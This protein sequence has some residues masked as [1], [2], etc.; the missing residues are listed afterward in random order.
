MRAL[1]IAEKKASQF[2]NEAARRLAASGARGINS[3][4]GTT[5]SFQTP[6]LMT[7]P[8]GVQYQLRGVHPFVH[9]NVIPIELYDKI[10]RE[11]KDNLENIGGEASPEALLPLLNELKTVR[12][13]LVHSC[14]A[15]KL[16]AKKAAS[17][18]ALR[19]IIDGRG[20]TVGRGRNSGEYSKSEPVDPEVEIRQ[21][22]L[23]FIFGS[24]LVCSD[25]DNA[26]IEGENI[27]IGDD[28]PDFQQK[29]IMVLRDQWILR[30]IK[31]SCTQIPVNKNVCVMIHGGN[32][33]LRFSTLRDGV[34]VGR[35]SLSHAQQIFKGS[36]MIEN[37]ALLLHA[38]LF[39]HLTSSEQKVVL[40]EDLADLLN[41][42]TD[43]AEIRI[44]GD[45]RL[46]LRDRPVFTHTDLVNMQ[47]FAA[48]CNHYSGIVYD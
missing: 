7:H 14:G 13:V 3:N 21:T 32:E 36:E 6:P 43:G 23:N 42:V 19:T 17:E 30:G 47:T 33:R 20:Y 22:C 10:F 40:K 37:M 2:L 8:S 41:A 9:E 38:I 18:G 15:G 1:R 34:A 29:G 35:V 24:A 5:R 39:Q 4:F 45:I 46:T 31:E 27:F 12:Y 11:S 44:S 25:G 26:R 48:K 28:H 16:G